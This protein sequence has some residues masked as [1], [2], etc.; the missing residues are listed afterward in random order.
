MIVDGKISYVRVYR[1][2]KQSLLL[3]VSIS[4]LVTAAYS[5]PDPKWL[6]EM[7]PVFDFTPTPLTVIGAA[8]SIFIGFRTTAGYSR[9]WE[10]RSLWGQLTTHSRGFTRQLD[11]YCQHSDR[12]GD[13]EEMI[14][15]RKAAVLRHIGFVYAFRDRLRGIDPL[16]T[17]GLVSVVSAEEFDGYA[18]VRNIPAAV[19]HQQGRELGYAWKR[20]W[21]Q[22]IHLAAIDSTLTEVAR[23]QGGC[24]R[25]NNTPLPPIYTFFAS[26]LMIVFCCLVPFGMVSSLHWFTPAVTFL[27]SFAFMALSNISHQIES[28]F[29][30]SDNDLPLT[31]LCRAIE[32]DLRE[33]VDA[34]P[35]PQAVTAMD[36]ILL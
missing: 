26:R 18:Q 35:L 23:V 15:W 2:L 7:R 12:A 27:V 22:E 25:I 9:W 3:T 4:L 14:A 1:S 19:L 21:L 33:R 13:K 16:D 8:L 24:E 17:D 10:G 31:S 20:G 34:Y 30:L 36:G 11:T 5:A 32:I 6:V 29:G 28:P